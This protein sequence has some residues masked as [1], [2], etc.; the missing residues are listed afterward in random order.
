MKNSTRRAA[1]IAALSG[2]TLAFGLV[3]A[4]SAAASTPSGCSSVRQLGPTAYVKYKGKTAAS[5]KQ[6]YGCGKMYGYLV[7][8]ESFRKSTK[9]SYASISVTTPDGH[10]HGMTL[11]NRPAYE[12][13]SG[14]YATTNC[15]TAFG[16]VQV[17]SGS[18]TAY[19]QTS[20]V[21]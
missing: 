9:W 1:S 14:G 6:Y 12:M 4:G 18:D 3:N 13:W 20:M 21:C 5:V 11:K 17:G 7:V 16:R 15:T 8:W 2:I 10:A 19:V